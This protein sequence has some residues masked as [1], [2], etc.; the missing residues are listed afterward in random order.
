MAHDH[1]PVGEEDGLV[2]IGGDEEIGTFLVFAELGEIFEHQ[3]LGHRVE[4]AERLV[5]DHHVGIVDE[6]AGEFGAAL[7]PAGQLRRIM[8]AERA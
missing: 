2:D 5:E 7:H 8:I 1:E 4:A 6:R 3:L